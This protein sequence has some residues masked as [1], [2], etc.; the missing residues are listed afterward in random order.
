MLK[1]YRFVFSEGVSLSLGYW[2]PDMDY[3]LCC[4]FIDILLIH[5][6]AY[7]SHFFSLVLPGKPSF[8]WHILLYLDVSTMYNCS[9]TA[10]LCCLNDEY[11]FKHPEHH[12]GVLKNKFYSNWY[13]WPKHCCV[14]K[15]M[16]QLFID[17]H[18]ILIEHVMSILIRFR[19]DGMHPVC[20]K[21]SCRAP[22]G[23]MSIQYVEVDGI[24]SETITFLLFRIL[25]R[26]RD[27][28]KSLP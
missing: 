7:F 27:T 5:V 15:I 24:P 10:E 1:I 4:V 14:L 25:P 28:M 3:C 13:S 16:M 19:I 2:V 18:V 21:A 17:Q 8:R 20:W 23:R 6:W 26:T 22:R 9:S 11:Y 12:S